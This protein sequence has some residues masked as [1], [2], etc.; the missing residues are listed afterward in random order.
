VASRLDVPDDRH[1]LGDGE[2]HLLANRRQRHGRRSIEHEAS[3][4][5]IDDEPRAELE[6]GNL[7][8]AVRR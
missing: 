2:R 7:I 5:W 6:G 4:P 8:E 1:Q 3:A